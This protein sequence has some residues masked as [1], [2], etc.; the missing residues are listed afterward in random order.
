MTG[1][2]GETQSGKKKLHLTETN[3]SVVV[4]QNVYN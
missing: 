4:T 3:K 1:I 2:Q